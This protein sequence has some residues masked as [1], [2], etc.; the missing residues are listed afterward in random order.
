[1]EY[2]KLNLYIF[3]FR[4]SILKT[5]KINIYQQEINP[6]RKPMNCAATILHLLLPMLI[7]ILNYAPAFITQKQAFSLNYVAS[8]KFYFVLAV[9]TAKNDTKLAKTA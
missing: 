8:T 4:Y 1:M 9:K 2:L 6:T 7:L 3:N 5:P